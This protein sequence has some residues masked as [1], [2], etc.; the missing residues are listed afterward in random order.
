MLKNMEIKGFKM[1]KY[2]FLII[3]FISISFY[4]YAETIEIDMV[5][6]LGKE[7]MVYS[8]KIAKIDIGDTIIWQSIDKGHNVEFKEMPEGVKKFKSIKYL[9]KIKNFIYLPPKHFRT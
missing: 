4:S 3:S 1:F 8:I 7:K 5:N 2:L 6:K 9:I